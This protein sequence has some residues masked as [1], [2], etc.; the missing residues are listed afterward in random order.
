MGRQTKYTVDKMQS[1]YLDVDGASAARSFQVR[2][3][4]HRLLL[5]AQDEARLAMGR[6]GDE[7]EMVSMNRR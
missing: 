1:A 5:A 3:S 6:R 7:E 2:Y 4:W